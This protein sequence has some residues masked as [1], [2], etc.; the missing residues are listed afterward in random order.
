MINTDD[1]WIQ[2]E[3]MMKGFAELCLNVSSPVNDDRWTAL[4]MNDKA[5]I[6]A[7]VY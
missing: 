5:G 4:W 1:S 6:K 3:Q 2:L 7:W